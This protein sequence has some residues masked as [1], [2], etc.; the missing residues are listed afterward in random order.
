MSTTEFRV[1][2]P[3][4]ALRNGE[5]LALGP[6]KQRALL[7]LLC[8]H[9]NEVVPL[10]RLIDGLWGEEP[11]ATARNALQGHVSGLRRALGENRVERRGTGYRLRVES[12]ELD[13]ERFEHLLAGAR[14]EE[15]LALWR[16]HA[17]ADLRDQPFAAQEAERLEE[18]RL[19]ALEQRIERDLARGRHE[20]LVAEL[21]R[22]VAEEPYRER[23]RVQLM[24]ALYRSGRQADALAAYQDGRG[25]LLEELGLEPG[26]EL[27]E[28]ERK[29][30]RQDA[31]LEAPGGPTVDLP[32]P[33]TPLVGRELEVAALVGLL[34]RDDSRLL[35]ITGP[36]GVGKTR[37][38]VEVASLVAGEFPDG[39]SFVDLAPLA[40]PELVRP[41]IAASLGEGHEVRLLVLD[42]FEHLL[43]AA[44]RVAE[45]LAAAPG[46]KVLAT[47][48]EPL[49]LSGEQEYPLPPLEQEAALTLFAERA[50]AAVPGFELDGRRDTV[51]EICRSLDRLPLAI[52]LAAARVKLFSPETLL[53]RLGE[54]L[55]FLTGGPR[56]LP[57]RQRTLRATID[58]SHSLLSGEE[59]VL[60]RRL[61][62][63]SGGFDVGAAEAVAEA[64]VDALASLLDKS[65]VRR[66]G[67]RLSL[68][69]TLREYASERL[70][71]SGE[72]EAIRGRHAEYFL[73]FA[74]EADKVSYG[75]AQAEWWGRL[76]EE[77]DNLRAA[78]AWA[79]D[80]GAAEAELRLS[81]AI[82]Y[83]WSV[84]GHFAEAKRALEGALARGAGEP[85]VLRG[86]ALGALGAAHY[87]RGELAEAE[88]C[89]EQAGVLFRE[90]GDALGTARM[91]GELGNLA[92]ARRDYVPA[93]EHYEDARARFLE[94]GEKSRVAAVVAN[95]G[96]VANMQG[97]Y[98]R[99]RQWLEEALALQR[100]VGNQEGTAIS[101]HNLSRIDIKQGR[102]VDGARLLAQSL[103]LCRELGYREVIAY[104]LE[105]FAEVA[106][107]VN[108]YVRAAQLLG[109]S[110]ALFEEIGAVM[111]PDEEETASETAGRAREALA[112]DAFEDARAAGR[113]LTLEEAIEA[114]QAL[115][116]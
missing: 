22:L 7:A 112:E 63:F 80:A 100:E 1:L 49:R 38:A 6:P 32:T 46:L 30:L 87:R 74:E 13:L 19:T 14:P 37:L 35:T 10:E 20:Q 3:L 8:L 36:G 97:D 2:G 47:S 26:P 114:A 93:M 67:E 103:D 59:Q 64:E 95:M 23:L 62:V 29:I 40:D 11:P 53:A 101:L 116:P 73:A 66:D 91:V 92:V 45:Q 15:A 83:W 75:G 28:L 33:P 24:L 102:P 5:P 111:S 58:W 70:A 34:R 76:A 104:C 61:G 79:V 9:A 52:E 86:R 43:D 78:L 17:L 18:L 82:W 72:A 51:A 69:E 68:L 41:T 55:P 16:G 25:T 60:F 48:R 98:D 50:A 106:A 71:E 96:S 27:Q 89:F 56:D 113:A 99:G 12:D 81:V 108:D 54:R 84:Q 44:P 110:E 21:E 31:E 90:A 107:A 77:H 39:A 109:A 88:A 85:P 115:V 57:A 42:N 4:E 65:L 105:G 94:I